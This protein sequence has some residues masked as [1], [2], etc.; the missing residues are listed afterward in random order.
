MTERSSKGAD[1]RRDAK[2][3]HALK[4][5]PLSREQLREEL[6]RAKEA[7]KAEKAKG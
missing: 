1:E 7:A 3:L 2:L 6:K 5:A 4:A